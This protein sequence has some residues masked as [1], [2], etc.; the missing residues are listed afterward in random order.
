MRLG[1]LVD[2]VPEPDRRATEDG[3]Q[4]SADHTLRALAD[5]A[6]SQHV[7][8]RLLDPPRQIT[9]GVKIEVRDLDAHARAREQPSH[10][11]A[12]VVPESVV[13]LATGLAVAVGDGEGGLTDGR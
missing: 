10:R 3:G 5:G 9:L 12:V 11:R 1:R 2:R 8:E 4:L 6:G 13:H 7:V